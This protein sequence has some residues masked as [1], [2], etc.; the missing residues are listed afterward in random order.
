MLNINSIVSL[1]YTKKEAIAIINKLTISL[2]SIT[3]MMMVQNERYGKCFESRK[4]ILHFRLDDVLQLCNERIANKFNSHRVNVGQWKTLKD[5]LDKIN[6]E[7][8]GKR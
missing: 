7:E 2:P 1:G 6:K 8:N 3:I 5:K 4:G